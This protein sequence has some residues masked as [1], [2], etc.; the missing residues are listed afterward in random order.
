[1]RIVS[2]EREHM[3]TA[4]VVLRSGV[5]HRTVNKTRSFGQTDIIRNHRRFVYARL[6]MLPSKSIY[7]YCI[8]PKFHYLHDTT[9][10]LPMHFGIGKS[11]VV[12]SGIRA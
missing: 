9:R 6:I 8:K 4:T 11:R 3:T 5:T 12:Q 2:A 1:M 7:S 10:Y